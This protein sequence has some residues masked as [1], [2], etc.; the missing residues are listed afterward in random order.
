MQEPHLHP[1][2]HPRHGRGPRASR[3]AVV[4]GGERLEDRTALAV[5][6]LAVA[7]LAVAPLAVVP[8]AVKAPLLAPAAP[9]VWMT[10]A[11]DTGVRDGI[12]ALGTPAFAG[13]AVPGTVLRVEEAGRLIGVTT[14][15]KSGDW[16]L[17]TPASRAFA[18][19]PHT[20]SVTAVAKGNV[21]SRATPYGFRIDNAAPTARLTYDSSTGRAVLRFSRPVTGVSPASLQL[22]GRTNSGVSLSMS[23]ADPRLA[24]FVGAVRMTTS[25]D[26]TTYTFSTAKTIVEPGS[27]QLTATTTPRIVDSLVGNAFKTAVS[28]RFS[29]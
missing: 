5:A 15:S 18:A 12:T 2:R 21:A 11:T 3:T 16:T 26:R 29:M 20:I 9:S 25:A 28:V 1:R 8:L 14:A 13:K 6:P 24:A 17:P 10:A 23:L 19:G 27:Y 22:S 7:P 4:F